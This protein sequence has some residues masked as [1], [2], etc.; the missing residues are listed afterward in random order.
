MSKASENKAREIKYANQYPKI[1]DLYDR[2][3]QQIRIKKEEWAKKLEEREQIT[4]RLERA[5]ARFPTK[6]SRAEQ[7]RTKNWQSITDD[8]YENYMS[9][10]IEID[11][12]LNESLYILDA[13]QSLAKDKKEVA[14]F[15]A[16][17]HNITFN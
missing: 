13:I 10:K 16:G 5:R 12:I 8:L 4:D 7:E 11:A 15:Y 2:V 9:E 14:L 6:E 3:T 17:M 1:N